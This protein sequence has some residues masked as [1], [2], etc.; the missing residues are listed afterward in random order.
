MRVGVWERSR[1]HFN[2]NDATELLTD[3]IFAPLLY[4]LPSSFG[5]SYERVE[6]G[7]SIPGQSLVRPLVVGSRRGQLVSRRR[8]K[9]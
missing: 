2:S 9:K 3:T 1:A 8:A 7:F 6:P 5:S 4:T